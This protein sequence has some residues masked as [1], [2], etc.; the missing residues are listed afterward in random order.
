M[1]KNLILFILLL[2]VVQLK[3]VQAARVDFGKDIGLKCQAVNKETGEQVCDLGFQITGGSISTFNSVT[4]TFTLHN[5]SFDSSDV[6]LANNWYMDKNSN[7]VYTFDTTDTSFGVGYHTMATIT[8]HKD[9]SAT[10]CYILYQYDFDKITRSCSSYQEVYYNKSGQQVSQE[11][12]L[13]ECFSH[14]C[15]VVNDHYYG[16]S[17]TKVQQDQY[18]S[19]CTEIEEKKYCKVE[20]QDDG[21]KKYYGK[22]GTEVQ[23]SVYK[24]DCFTH[25]CEVIDEQHYDNEGNEVEEDEFKKDCFPHYCEFVDN[26][27][28]D[29]NGEEVDKEEYEAS[30][31]P[32]EIF[33]CEVKDGVYYGIEGNVVTKEKHEIE[34]FKHSCEVVYGTYFDLDGTVIDKETYDKHCASIENPSTGEI[35]PILVVM[36]LA[37]SGLMI[38]KYTKN[39]NKFI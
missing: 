12:Y 37:G 7:T 14:Y 22:E 3:D 2:F 6:K 28:Y 15:E 36:F 24:K 21:S 10:D 4:V 32:S 23:E 31:K 39:R 27:Y 30:C 17:G 16:S 20:D 13:E 29:I 25:I 33:V 34:C 38:Y 8:F 19:E 35:Y 1:K 18:Q 26:T 5:V 11:V 9:L